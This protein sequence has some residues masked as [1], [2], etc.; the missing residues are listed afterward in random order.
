MAFGIGGGCVMD[1]GGFP[2]RPPWPAQGSRMQP[3]QQPEAMSG[4]PG[5][6][7]PWQQG[8]RGL[9]G[10][11][12]PGPSPGPGPGLGG[13]AGAGSPS[14]PQQSLAAQA[15]VLQALQRNVLLGGQVSHLGGPGGNM[16]AVLLAH[17]QA[18]QQ[19]A[20]AG[21]LP[22]FQQAMLQQMHLQQR[23]QQ[24]QLE[25]QKAA[26]VP[27]EELRV[28]E[29]A[30]RELTERN[31]QPQPQQQQQQAAAGLDR[32]RWR[33]GGPGGA[34]VW[35]GQPA[36]GH[37]S[38][39][40]P[41]QGLPLQ[42]LPHGMLPLAQLTALA[43]AGASPEKRK[44][45]EAMLR[46]PEAKKAH[47]AWP[48]PALPAA[49]PGAASMPGAASPGTVV[50]QGLA[51]QTGE[52][53]V[54]AALERRG[55]GQV[56][57]S[58]RVACDA[59]GV[60]Q[61][62]AFADFLPADAAQAV[63]DS[64]QTAGSLVVD[65][66]FVAVQLRY[67]PVLLP[68]PPVLG[69]LGGGGQVAAAAVSPGGW[70]CLACGASNVPLQR[71]CFKCK[72]PPPSLLGNRV[73]TSGAQNGHPAALPVGPQAPLAP[74]PNARHQ[75]LHVAGG[76]TPSPSKA[77]F[78]QQPRPTAQAIPPSEPTHVLMVRG[79]DESS[80]EE[81]LHYEFS[82]HAPIKEL[83]FLRDK[84]TNRPRGFA[85]VHFYSVEDATKALEATSGTLRLEKG[86]HLL[87]VMYAR[88][89]NGPPPTPGL[90]GPGP[91]PVPVLRAVSDLSSQYESVGW[92]PKE[93]DPNGIVV[94]E[95]PA[96][97]AAASAAAASAGEGGE[98]AATTLSGGLEEGLAQPPVP[99]EEG[100]PP[101]GTRHEADAAVQADSDA[102]ARSSPFAEGAGPAEGARTPPEAGVD[103]GAEAGADADTETCA[104]AGAGAGTKADAGADADAIESTS[105]PPSS[106]APSSS[107]SPSPR[108]LAIP[109]PPPP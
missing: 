85:F 90:M 32:D 46:L 37:Y 1:A 2:L 64:C 29:A 10:E 14:M 101:L 107:Q 77:P 33:A 22:P 103:A 79:L 84:V 99:T 41:N 39:P 56:L 63:V 62:V 65:G 95:D 26:Q 44:R 72:S 59:V 91:G 87:R 66:Q 74:Q 51:A 80:M 9:Q 78:A 48:A 42:Q 68:G 16:A 47:M 108:P 49:A 31:M 11:S 96:A 38:Q 3:S 76:S 104:D 89:P 19:A 25:H 18:Q 50:I 21:G 69:A 36:N 106:Q 75:L 54:V 12:A 82:K 23:Q 83:R 81:N 98:Q 55:F 15:S 17:G 58:V 27:L 40:G 34:A 43:A 102:N 30:Q 7:A 24:Q 61:G 6:G 88:N 73:A 45:E 8:M 57:R 92:A 94:Q 35:R 5:G 28:L 20:M 60:S 53:A 100:Q 105:R 67:Q 93:Y 52:G 4:V 109:P 70:M 97:A 13:G 71:E 86:G